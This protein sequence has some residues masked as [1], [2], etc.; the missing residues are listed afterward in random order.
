MINNDFQVEIA[1][2]ETDFADL[3]AIREPVFV[4]E[5]QVPAEIELDEID[6][7]CRHVLAR[8]PDGRPIGTG[9]LTPQRTIG[10]L[11]V[12]PE[13]RG[14]GVGEALL[15]ALV[16]LARSLGYPEIELH[17]QVSAIGFYEKFAFE[18]IG[19]EYL[20]AGI[21]HRNMR[22]TLDPF[23]EV[24]RAALAPRPQSNEV[25]IDSLE[26]AHGI[27]LQIVAQARRQVWLYSRDLDVKLYG[28]PAMLEAI[29]R[30]AIESRGGQLRI[31]LQDPAAALRDTHPLIPLVQRL[32]STLL[33]RVPEVE[34]DLQYA[35]AFLL[36][37]RGGYLL[38]PIGSRYEGTA[39]LYSPGRQ[40]QLREYFEQ[41]WE[42][43]L[44]SPELRPVHI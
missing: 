18:C 43:S 24:T 35:G 27:A 10:R 29:K 2:Y 22:R 38:R 36:A 34:Q 5:Q 42:R 7:R 17:S 25:A 9:R 39:D 1:H 44:P 15:Q 40:R 33:V 13:W 23:P 6:P 30:F 8:D 21:R 41:V 20:E 12:L 16:D 4:V 31:L 28:T 3:R 26:A 14:R 11:A 19:D 37:D 32:S